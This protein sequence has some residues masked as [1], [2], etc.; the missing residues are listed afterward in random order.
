MSPA[1]AAGIYIGIFKPGQGTG[2]KSPVPVL[3]HLK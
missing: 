3:V 1:G 2:S